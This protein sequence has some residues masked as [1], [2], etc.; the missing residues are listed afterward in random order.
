MTQ[1]K[2]PQAIPLAIAASL[3]WMATIT[4][5]ALSRVDDTYAVGAFML[6]YLFGGTLAT[7][8][9]ISDLLEG[10]VNVDLLMVLAAAG[11]AMLGHWLEGAILLGLFSTSNALEF[12]AMRRTRNAVRALMDMTPPTAHV[13]VGDTYLVKDVNDVRVGDMVLIQPGERIP[14]DARV[15]EGSSAVD[16]AAITGESAPVH[17]NINDDVFAGTINGNGSLIVEVTRLASDTTLA[18]IVALVA[19]AQNDQSDLQEFAEGFEGKYA[20]FVIAVSA[21]VTLIP[22]MFGVSSGDAFYR[23]MT[24]L[25]VMSPCALVI[26]TP[27]AT[28]SALANAARRG[29]LIKGGRALDTMGMIDTVAFD[30]TGTLTYGRPSVTDIVV[31]DGLDSASILATAAAVEQLSEH[32]LGAAIVAAAQTQAIAIP[33]AENLQ[34][35]PGH[36][37]SAQVGDNRVALG[38]RRMM[39]L[40]GIALPQTALDYHRNLGAEGK[41]PIFVT[42]NRQL[43]AII[44]VADALRPHVPETLARLRKLGVGRTVMLSGD[45]DHVAATVARR[46][47]ID[48]VRAD[49][50]PQDKL[51]AIDELKRTGTVAM[52]GDGVNDAPAL[53]KAH[54]GIAMGGVGTDVALETADVV[55]MSDDLTKVGYAIELSRKTR[56]IIRMN[57]TFALGVIAVLAV[58]NLTIGIPLTLGVIGHEGSTVLVILNGLRL[59]G[60][61]GG[62]KNLIHHNSAP[63]STTK[64]RFQVIAA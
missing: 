11:S 23:G 21:L 50:L 43:V 27:A 2:E 4:G 53:A 57:L 24:L 42:V 36:G 46:I 41:T 52:V 62:W 45:T 61:G 44:A 5:F 48:E 14:V 15:I 30:K 59:L 39:N 3:T 58:L 35:Y 12:Y 37:V 60:Y 9:A 25:V 54:I 6:A 10:H 28:L 32:P 64:P 40:D 47:G 33:I 34:A 55:L 63:A 19:D 31:F 8:D 1:R 29:I 22:M 18:R 49:L 7:R 16:Q 38:N 13:Q 51:I 17:K 20:V 56:R 26:S